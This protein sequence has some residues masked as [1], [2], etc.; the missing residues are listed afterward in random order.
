MSIRPLTD[1]ER[2]VTEKKLAEMKEKVQTLNGYIADMEKELQE[3]TWCSDPEERITAW[4]QIEHEVA[5]W[6]EESEQRE[7][8]QYGRLLTGSERSGFVRIPVKEENIAG[9]D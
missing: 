9:I 8:E 6:N 4:R 5:M 1:K 3:G 2:A 7:V